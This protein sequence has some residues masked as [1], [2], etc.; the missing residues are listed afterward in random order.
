M[1]AVS[2]S[3]V[4][5]E[6]VVAEQSRPVWFNADILT[7]PGGQAKPLE[8]EAFLS[9]VRTLPAHTVL[10]LGWTTGWTAGTDNPGVDTSVP[11]AVFTWR[12]YS[13]NNRRKISPQLE[14]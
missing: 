7:G 4:L 8:P 5:L 6:E 9:A 3:V 2:P 14:K 1:E 12:L 10:S 13:T 11:L